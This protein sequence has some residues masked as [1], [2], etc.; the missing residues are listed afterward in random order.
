MLVRRAD[1][2]WEETIYITFLVSVIDKL[3]DEE[4]DLSRDLKI[5]MEISKILWNRPVKMRQEE[6][7]LI[8]IQSKK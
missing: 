4:G 3:S 6:K 8:Q 5:V 2:A 1:L 7:V